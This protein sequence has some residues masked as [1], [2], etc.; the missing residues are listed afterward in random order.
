ME[1][2][3]RS[4]RINRHPSLVGAL[5][6]RHI[7]NGMSLLRD[8]ATLEL[9]SASYISGKLKRRES[10]MVWRLTSSKPLP[11]VYVMVEFQTQVDPLMAA[12]LLEYTYLL[13]Q[14][15]RKETQRA[16]YPRALPHVIALV[17]YNGVAPWTAAVDYAELVAYAPGHEPTLHFEYQLLDAARVA[18]RETDPDDLI[19]TLCRLEHPQSEDEFVVDG[20]RALQANPDNVEWVED[21]R[22]WMM[23]LVQDRGFGDKLVT[24]IFTNG[25]DMRANEFF[26]NLKQERFQAG[27]TEGLLAGR[28]EGLLAGRT[29]GLLAG[30][31][32]GLLVA[33]RQ[34]LIRLLERKFGPHAMT[35]SMRA[36]I[37]AAQREQLEVWLDAVL[38]AQSVSEVMGGAS[39]H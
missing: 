10:D 30:R 36:T 26:E 7:A 4:R 24:D 9:V 27:R 21:V 38:D 37:D 13:Q 32:E 29:E 34:T 22:I 31:T 28:T 25:D 18:Q 11:P 33:S 1:H 19:A 2:D 15:S 20:R 39:S 14:E 12:R 17:Y 23:S 3:L 35:Q 8:Y 16:R 6:Q 5:I